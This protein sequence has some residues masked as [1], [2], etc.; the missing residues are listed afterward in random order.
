MTTEGILGDGLPMSTGLEGN[1]KNHW[2]YEMHT[3]G[4]GRSAQATRA[5]IAEDSSG[6]HAARTAPLSSLLSGSEK[7]VE[8]RGGSSVWRAGAE[9]RVDTG[10]SVVA[11]TASGVRAEVGG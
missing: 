1:M 2:R 8:G 6:T 10:D 7:G 9:A 11:G 3:A 5:H 4:Y